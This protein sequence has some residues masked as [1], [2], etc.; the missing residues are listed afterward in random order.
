MIVREDTEF[1]RL[2]TSV[3]VNATTGSLE[4]GSVELV[5]NSAG[6]ERD[7]P[8]NVPDEVIP[9]LELVCVADVVAELKDRGSLVALEDVVTWTELISVVNATADD[10]CEELGCEL[11]R[12]NSVELCEMLAGED[13]EKVGYN[14]DDKTGC[15]VG[16]GEVL[17]GNRVVDVATEKTAEVANEVADGTVVEE[18]IVEI[19]EEVIEES[20]AELTAECTVEVVGGVTGTEEV[21][22]TVESAI[23][24]KNTAVEGDVVI[25]LNEVATP[26]EVSSS[27][28]GVVVAE[29]DVGTALVETATSKDVARTVGETV[30]VED[31]VGTALEERLSALMMSAAFTK[32]LGTYS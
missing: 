4:N 21:A 22:K 12:L 31:S 27:I 1:G 13:A 6:L 29:E 23:V 20:G 30:A 8:V 17:A 24:D 25:A 7:R 19:A 28:D 26:E 2:E 3:V 5:D 10:V 32:A 14:V 9:L 18:A 16:F 15:N 11:I